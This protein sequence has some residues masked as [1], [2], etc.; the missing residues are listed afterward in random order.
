MTYLG[1]SVLWLIN[2]AICVWLGI[3][4][5][6]PLLGAILGVFITSLVGILIMLLI[7][8]KAQVHWG[9]NNRDKRAPN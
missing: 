7:P 5:D 2:V 6:R 4:K 9:F 1:L 8:P 3:R